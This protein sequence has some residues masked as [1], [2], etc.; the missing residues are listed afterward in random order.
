MKLI[1][2]FAMFAGL[3]IMVSITNAQTQNLN[4]TYKLTNGV[5]NI[6]ATTTNPEVSWFNV[7]FVVQDVQTGAIS[8]TYQFS[9]RNFSQGPST[10]TEMSKDLATF[11]NQRPFVVIL[12]QV[13][14]TKAVEFKS[15]SGDGSRF[16]IGPVSEGD[17]D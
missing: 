14:G 7:L 15:A 2:R 1:N 10:V 17:Y 13:V 12:V 8:T 11:C 6:K 5:A 3:L 9:A 16:P 4:F